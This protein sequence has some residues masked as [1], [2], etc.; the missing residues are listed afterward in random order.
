[1]GE[2][3][4]GLLS[5]PFLFVLGIG[6]AGGLVQGYTGWGAAMLMMPLMTL[7]YPPIEALALLVVGGLLVSA[8]LYPSA[9]R[10]FNWT[11]MR[12]LLL[13]LI[14][15]TPIGSIILLSADPNLVRKIIGGFL[16]LL[17]VL[18]LSGWQYRGKRGAAAA[19]LFGGVA[20]IINGFAGLGSPI[21]AIY[22]MAFPGQAITQR[23]NLIVAS[24]LIIFTIMII[25]SLNGIMAWSLILTGILLAPTQMIG[26]SI[27][28][29]IFAYSPKEH[30]K[31]I[32]LIIILIL[33]VAVIIFS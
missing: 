1:M 27:G 29:R 23:S 11:D 19:F 8:Q 6:L 31:K 17:S 5:F 21:L 22:I 14:L 9:I 4:S 28:A 7:V 30:F 24:G 26:A 10:E 25:F 15:L 3:V 12:I 20:G 33:G 13:T 16:V 2:F 32:T 18:V